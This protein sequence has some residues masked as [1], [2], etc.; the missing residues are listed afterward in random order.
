MKGLNTRSQVYRL[1]GTSGSCLRT[2]LLRVV[3]PVPSEVEQFFSRPS[4]GE[5]TAQLKRVGK[6][7][8]L[9]VSR[10]GSFNRVQPE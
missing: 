2:V 1:A 6:K 8:E 9:F 4:E 5:L 3:S 7:N 10:I